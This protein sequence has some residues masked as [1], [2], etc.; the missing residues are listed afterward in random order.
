MKKIIHSFVLSIVSLSFY[1]QT[2][3]YDGSIY[4]VNGTFG[5][6]QQLISISG[7]PN[8]FTTNVVCTIN[9]SNYQNGLA[10]NHLDGYIYYRGGGANSGNLFKLDNSGNSTLVC[11]NKLGQT[12]SACFD[13]KGRYAFVDPSGSVSVLKILDLNACQIVKQFNLPVKTRDVI[14]NPKNCCYYFVEWKQSFFGPKPKI[15]QMDTNG[16]VIN[17]VTTSAFFPDNGIAYGRDGKLYAIDGGNDIWKGDMNTG[18]INAFGNAV[19]PSIVG[20]PHADLAS[21]VRKTLLVDA[22]TNGNIVS[23]C[24]PLTISFY[25]STIADSVMSYIWNFGDGTSSSMQNPAHTYTAAGTYTVLLTVNDFS[26]FDGQC[27]IYEPNTDTIIITV[28]PSATV[29]IQNMNN[30]TCY[31][32]NNGNIS[33]NI[34]GG[35]PPYSFL[36]NNGQTSSTAFNLSAGMYSVNVTDSK[37]CISQTLAILTQPNY[38]SVGISSPGKICENKLAIITS[39][40]LGGTAPYVLS[41]LPFNTNGTALTFTPVVGINN[42]SLKVIDANNC[43]TIATNSLMVY[44]FPNLQ[45]NATPTICLGGVTNMYGLGAV[46]YSWSSGV[47]HFSTSVSPA[48]NTIYTLT[49]YNEIG[50]SVTQTIQVNVFP[51][52]D[53]DIEN[54]PKNSCAPLCLNID[55]KS[56]HSIL[57]YKWLVNDAL[58]STKTNLTDYCF[59]NAGVQHITLI[60]TDNNGC[61]NK[62]TTSVE[63]YPKP[64]AYFETIGQYTTLE[65]EVEFLD[66]SESDII[67]WL[68]YFGDGFSSDKKYVKHIYPEKPE[69]YA[70]FLTV[71]NKYGCV[72]TAY[73]KIVIDEVPVIYVPNSFTPNGDGLNDIF[74]AKGIAI[75]DYKLL[76]FDRWGKLIFESNSIDNGWDGNIKG[77]PA[78]ND[79]YVW[80]IIYSTHRVKSE[81]IT[82]HI[83]L[84]K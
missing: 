84:M 4:Y 13:Y 36:W 37:G 80:K 26:H 44:A 56:N 50:C 33:L 62:K 79:T 12:V 60:L 30:P 81:F 18:I 20:A 77:Q 3:P 35:T 82:G 19:N 29:S 54:I 57:Q 27:G 78:A 52:P 47:S 49:G 59:D 66:Y 22:K 51:L 73:R 38:L 70:V 5:N 55:A 24:A 83:Y 65:N 63:V 15:Y 6:T 28:N 8:S 17:S 16:V 45:I 64:Q 61:V 67:S 1:S 14:F 74:T 23:G 43:V 53:V 75:T 25:A 42:Y 68:W 72:D 40:V 69:Q 32:Y 48:A 41:W 34:T 58:S 46:S 76:V 9:S 39:T 10:A 31:G 71:K 11:S 21:F 7:Y 2:F